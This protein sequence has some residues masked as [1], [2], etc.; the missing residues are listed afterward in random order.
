MRPDPQIR[1]LVRE[2][3]MANPLWGA[4]RIHDELR[5]LGVDLSELTLSRLLEFYTRPRP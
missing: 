2:M 4:P 1:A 3:A 5:T